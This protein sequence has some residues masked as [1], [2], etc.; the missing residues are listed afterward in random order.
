M[1]QDNVIEVRQL[2]K[3]YVLGQGTTERYST[4]RDTIARTAVAFS[5]RAGALAST[6]ERATTNANVLHAL[7][8]VTFDVK[9]GD[10]VGIVGRNGAGKS[11]LLRLLS[12]ITEPTRGHIDLRGRVGSLLEVG[13]GFHPE[14][15]GRENI[16]LNGAILG[17]K[18][19]DVRRNFDAIVEFAE[20]ERFLDT[21]VKRYSSGMYVRLAFAVAA[22]LE[23]EILVVDEVLAVG[24]AQFQRKCLGKMQDVSRN[25]GRTVLFVSHHM[26]SVLLLCKSAILLENGTVSRQGTTAAIVDRYLGLG[27][28]QSAQHDLRPVA[29]ALDCRDSARLVSVTLVSDDAASGW[30]L[31]FESE[32]ELEFELEVDRSLER[33]ELALA[34][35]TATGFEIASSLSS[36]SRPIAD[37]TPGRYSFRARYVSLD[38]VPGLYQFGVALRSERGFEDYMPRAFELEIIVSERS[39]AMNVQSFSGALVPRVLYGLQAVPDA[40]GRPLGSFKSA[41][42]DDRAFASAP[43]SHITGT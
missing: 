35:S 11:T 18:R 25:N 16:F 2:G 26:P 29:R 5:R 37:I 12:R 28:I 32:I 13:T 41:S 39:A 14:L 36:H 17:M 33:L 43:T 23:T 4:L 22:H 21:P 38:L 19:H 40:S 30:K 24:D 3:D 31:P 20:V 1:D 7:H 8:D 27:V 10:V 9:R 15:S 34:L 42:I 6:R